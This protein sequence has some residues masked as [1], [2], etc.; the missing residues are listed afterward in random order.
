MVEQPATIT[1]DYGQSCRLANPALLAPRAGWRAGWLGD[2]AFGERRDA[3]WLPG[4]R[5]DVVFRSRITPLDDELPPPIRQIDLLE[6]L[7]S[8]R[9]QRWEV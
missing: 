1:I 8:H 7:H 5:N 9:R 2:L 6:I 3:D 4:R